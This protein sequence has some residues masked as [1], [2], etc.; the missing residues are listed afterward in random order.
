M[1]T[2]KVIKLTSKKFDVAELS[3]NHRILYN[4]EGQTIIIKC[5]RGL[6]MKAN[7]S[8]KVEV[9][10]ASQATRRYPD[11]FTNSSRTMFEGDTRTIIL[12]VPQEMYLFC[13]R[14]GNITAYL[15]SLIDRE[16]QK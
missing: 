16:M 14:Q 3:G 2:N 7:V 8:G 4:K 5:S 9:L 11:V 1:E 15:R 12:R 6:A 13:C 10:T